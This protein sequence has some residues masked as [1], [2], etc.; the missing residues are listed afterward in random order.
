MGTRPTPDDQVSFSYSSQFGNFS[1]F[2]NSS[3]FKVFIFFQA[4]F[5]DTFFKQQLLA[6]NYSIRTVRGNSVLEMTHKRA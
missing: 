3:F 5:A 2:P 6:F 4:A 1:F